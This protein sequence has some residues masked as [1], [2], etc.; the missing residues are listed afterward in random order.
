MGINKRLK[1]IKEKSGSV[2]LQVGVAT[3]PDLHTPNKIKEHSNG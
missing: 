2:K 1:Q 3:G